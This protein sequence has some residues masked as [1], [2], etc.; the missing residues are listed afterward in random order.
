M[1]DDTVTRVINEKFSNQ[2]SKEHKE[3]LNLGVEAGEGCTNN[4]NQR[5]VTVEV[6]E[7]EKHIRNAGC[8]A[9]ISFGTDRPSHTWSG[10][11]GSGGTEC[12]TIDICAGHASS[13]RTM[14]G[15]K[16]KALGKENVVGKMMHSDAARIY[17]SQQT[18]VDDNFGL[19]ATKHSTSTGMSAVAVKADHVRVIGRSSVKIWA[20][21]GSFSNLPYPGELNARAGSIMSSC[22]IEL[23]AGDSSKLQPLVKGTNLQK[24]LSNIYDH[25]SRINQALLLYDQSIL[26]LRTALC[27]HFHTGAGVGAIV[28][29]PDPILIAQ[30]IACFPGEISNVVNNSVESMN[31]ELNKATYLGISPDLMGPSQPGKQSLA[32]MASED[33]ILSDT[34]FTT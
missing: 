24:C 7:N 25:I 18:D 21:K 12:A 29:F 15:G 26:T 9:S 13:L 6:A 11:G 10:Y 17:I 34:V 16:A 5:V 23:I 28:T 32:S 20:G 33:Y 31:V 19:P 3:A 30:M 22:T 2:T 4:P 8:N 1:S 14:E 27:G